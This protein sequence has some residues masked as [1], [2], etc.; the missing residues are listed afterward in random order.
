M[1]GPSARCPCHFLAQ[2]R[3]RCFNSRRKAGM[4]F[5]I[6]KNLC[7]GTTIPFQTVIPLNRAQELT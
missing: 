6:T 3:S 1:G 4:E 2:I 5:I 7:K